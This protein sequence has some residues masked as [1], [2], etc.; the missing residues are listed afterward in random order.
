MGRMLAFDAG[1]NL[2][3]GAAGGGR[4]P[5]SGSRRI[6]G[7]AKSLG[8]AGRDCDHNVRQIIL[9]ERP[10][11]IGFASPFVGQIR[12]FK[13]RPIPIQP[14]SIRP[15]FSFLT[16]IEMVCDELQIRCVEL[17]EPEAR[18]ALGVTAR[19]SKEIKIDV[20]RCLR[21]R[22][23]MFMD[24]HAADALCIA[25]RMVEIFNPGEAH[26]TTPLFQPEFPAATEEVRVIARAVKKR[27]GK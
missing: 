21:Q 27:K 5:A 8:I 3:Y 23:L 2:G 12:D 16:I 13:G 20:Q 24:E 11:I 18:R 15:L 7:T 9:R 26:E 19:K 22:G 1:F 4:E 14:D 6:V 10:A 17:D 25:L